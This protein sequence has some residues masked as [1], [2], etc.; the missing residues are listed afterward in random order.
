[1]EVKHLR[2][3]PRPVEV[4]DGFQRPADLH[5]YVGRQVKRAKRQ[6]SRIIAIVASEKGERG[7]ILV[8]ATP[9]DFES[10]VSRSLTPSQA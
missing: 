10:C 3:P 4:M 6:G 9:V 1:M 2:L 5:L 7:D 8:F